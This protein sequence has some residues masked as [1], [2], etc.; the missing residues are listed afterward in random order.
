MI[1]DKRI[2]FGSSLT[3]IHAVNKFI[4]DICDHY[5][6][7]NSYFGH[8]LTAVTEA[9]QNAILHGN[10]N[11]PE[12]N[13]VLQFENR[14]EGL[15]FI[16]SDEGNGFNPDT[17]PDPTDINNDG[18]TGR[19]IFLMRALSDEISFKDHGSSVELLFIITGIDQD[20]AAARAD[21]VNKYFEAVKKP[22]EKQVE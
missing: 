15:C 2:S 7:F 12:K 9:V 13:V 20:V 22:S 4:E 16:I 1:K 3:N 8:I 5:N 10:Q 19:G 11:D 18:L 6:I 21:Q 14:S 17:L